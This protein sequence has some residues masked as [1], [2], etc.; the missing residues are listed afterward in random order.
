[1]SLKK[2]GRCKSAELIDAILPQFNHL[3]NIVKNLDRCITA[4]VENYINIIF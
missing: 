3:I 4:S 2:I 1:M